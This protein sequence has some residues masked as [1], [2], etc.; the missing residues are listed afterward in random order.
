MSMVDF[1]FLRPI[2]LVC[3]PLVTL[4]WFLWHRSTDPMRGWRLFIPAE[5]L[6]AFTVG[7]HAPSFRWDLLLLVAWN[8]T[9]VALA[10]PSWK[11]EPSPLGD[12]P[13]PVMVVLNAS[14]SMKSD[15]LSPTRLERAHLKIVDFAKARSNQPLGLIAYSGTAHLVLPPTRDTSV[16]AQM[17]LEVSPEIMPKEGDALLD[18]LEIAN[19]SFGDVKGSILLVTDGIAESSGNAMTDF[20]SRHSVPVEVLAIGRTDTPEYESIRGATSGV[21]ET[22]LLTADSKDIERLVRRTSRQTVRVES[23]EDEVRWADAGYWFLP[24]IAVLVACSFIQTS[25]SVGGDE[26]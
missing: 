16:V 25:D 7:D 24:F 22:T 23:G 5:M 2:W 13:I 9:V 10:G 14:E 8:L 26:S 6:K 15:D 21:A 19:A 4:V 3:I 18:A 1:H 11:Q 17:A 20:R 12:N